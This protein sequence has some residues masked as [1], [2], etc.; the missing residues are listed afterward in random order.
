M[1][2]IDSDDVYVSCFDGAKGYFQITLDEASQHLTVFMTPWRRYKSQRASMGLGFSSDEFN[3]QADATFDHL[4]N[5]VRVVDHLLRFD[6]SFPVHAR[7]VCSV[8]QAA[9]DAGFTFNSK[10]SSLLRRSA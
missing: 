4:S 8:V 1:L 2:E 5:T 6:R 10:N 7:G 9:Q 3:R